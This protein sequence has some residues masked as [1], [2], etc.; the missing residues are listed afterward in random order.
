MTVLRIPPLAAIGLAAVLLA[1]CGLF[2]RPEIEHYTLEA[3]PPAGPPAAVGGLPL[4]VAA[5]ELPPGLDRQDIVV[6]GEEEGRLE[7]R[8]TE[9]WAAPLGTMVLHTLAFD[10]AARL[11]EGMVVLPGQTR[12]AGGVRSLDVVFE[13]LVAGPEPEVVLDARWTLLSAVAGEADLTGR[14][15]IREPVDSLDSA[16]VA[17]GTSRALA[18]LA[19]RITAGLAGESTGG[20]RP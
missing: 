4:G 17:A 5:V 6:R 11:P 12:P 18:R 10:L 3:V 19:E 8:G 15:Q 14:E 13:E 16:D 2:S 20:E 1:G 9:L 7:V